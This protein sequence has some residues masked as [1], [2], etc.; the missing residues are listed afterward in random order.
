VRKAGT[1]EVLRTIDPR[2]AGKVEMPAPVRQALLDGLVGVTTRD[3]GTATSVFRG[4]PNDTWTVAAKTGTA[5]VSKKADTSV[6]AAFGPAT[7]PQYV[8]SVFLEESGFGGVAAAP[9][10]RRLFDVLSGFKPMPPAPAEGI[11]LPEDQALA[12]VASGG[13]D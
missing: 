5:Q 11:F 3:G 4:F 8:I 9:V 6:F 2:I 10:A 1:D 13:E 7:A 12:G